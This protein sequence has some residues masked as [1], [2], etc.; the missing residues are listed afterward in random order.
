MTVVLLVSVGVAV[1][2]SHGA[3]LALAGWGWVRWRG[4]RLP[5]PSLR[6]VLLMLLVEVRSGRSILAAL[7]AAS[8]VFPAHDQLVRS[9]RLAT[10]A[11]LAAALESSTGPMRGI[12]SQLA[13]AQRSGAPLADTIRSMIEDDLAAEKARRLA[14][15]RSLPVRLMI[16]LTVLVLPGLILLLYAPSIV[17]LLEDISVPLT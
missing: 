14:R 8:H 16:P 7:Q 3:A 17:G 6:P 11:G 1:A 15:A 10:V 12:L 2:G 9:A 4:R 5:T 13:R